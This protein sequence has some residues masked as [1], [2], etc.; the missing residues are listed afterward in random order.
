MLS[1]CKGVS[2]R[3]S[4]T[5]FVSTPIR[6]ELLAHHL[7][8]GGGA[9]R[10]ITDD[11]SRKTCPAPGDVRIVVRSL[12]G[13]QVQGERAYSPGIIARQCG[14]EDMTLPLLPVYQ[15]SVF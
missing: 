9:A 12:S 6:H 1:T 4:R 8:D 7:S 15:L 2:Q 14:R 10:H 5:T 3:T 13:V 11:G